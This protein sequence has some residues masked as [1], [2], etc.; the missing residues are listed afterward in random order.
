MLGSIPEPLT[1]L[2]TQPKFLIPT[3]AQ[4]YSY[5]QNQANF[6]S[7]NL[8]TWQLTTPS[9]KSRIDKCFLIQYTVQLVFTGSN[10]DPSAPL[11]ALGIGD[12]P[13]AYPLNHAIGSLNLQLNSQ[14]FA[15]TNDWI[16]AILRMDMTP[17]AHTQQSS[18]FPCMLDV[19]PQFSNWRNLPGNVNNTV[20]GQ[21]GGYSRNPLIQG[22]SGLEVGRGSWPITVISNAP[23]STTATIQ[24]TA[25][26]PIVFPLFDQ[27][28]MSGYDDAGLVGIQ[29]LN[30][31]LSNLN[32]SKMWSHDANTANGMSTIT[33]VV[34]SWVGAPILMFRS[35]T[36]PDSI[37]PHVEYPFK[38]VNYNVTSMSSVAAG[39]TFNQLSN[40]FT[41]NQ[42][43]AKLLIFLPQ[44]NADRN[45]NSSQTFARI[46]NISIQFG[47]SPSQLSTCYPIDLYRMSQANGYQYSYDDWYNQSGSVLIVVP[48]RD[49]PLPYSWI[50]GKAAPVTIQCTVQGA[51]LSPIAITPALYMVAFDEATMCVDQ[52]SLYSQKILSLSDADVATALAN[53]VSPASV[54]KPIIG[55][56]LFASFQ[57]LAQAAKPYLASA[58]TQGRGYIGS[59]LSGGRKMMRRGLRGAGF[60]DSNSD[61]I[62]QDVE[63]AQEPLMKKR[64]Y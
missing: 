11:L 17:R 13:S 5:T 7:N 31:T 58:L 10:S 35:C 8:L 51:N 45:Q 38:N 40:S 36:I 12:A 6:F 33:N 20:I 1:L 55:G 37:P 25:T 43:P 21:S 54:K 26:E 60:V 56:T 52:G 57:Q 53:Q 30:L 29:Q 41:V 15:Q 42:V 19:F 23:G 24:Y 46:Q 18:M 48:G 49:F 28:L 2:K 47:E 39:A 32:M 50:A 3:G 61:E 59:A 64:R 44:Q 16:D 62:E 9:D 4:A 34:G 14:S 63:D 22:I 27:D